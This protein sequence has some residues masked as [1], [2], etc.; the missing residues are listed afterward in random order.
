MNKPKEIETYE[1]QFSQNE[2][3]V[4]AVVGANGFGGGRASGSDYWTARV[5][6]TAIKKVDTAGVEVGEFSLEMKADDKQLK[7]LQQSVSSNSLIRV[8]VRQLN[9]RLLL[10]E[11]LETNV[12]NSELQQILSEQI[13]PVFYNDEK[14]GVFELD[15]CISTFEKK[16]LWNDTSINLSFDQDT[17]ANMTSALVTAHVLMENQL[18][19]DSRIRQ[20]AVGELLELKNDNWLDEGEVEVSAETFKNL[21]KLYAISVEPEGEFVFWFDDGD[22]FWGHSI[23]VEG[24]LSGEFSDAN[25]AG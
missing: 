1:A 11:L 8:R 15:K 24:N 20:Y 16:L 9:N 23:M 18:D 14:L 7:E 13:K 5:N 10:L 21:M 19:W 3:E 12:E 4:I 17:E 25:I 6:L 2:Y 22:L